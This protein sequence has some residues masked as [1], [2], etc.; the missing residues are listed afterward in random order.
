MNVKQEILIMTDID[1]KSNEISDKL[2]Q[3][4][5]DKLQEQMNGLCDVKDLTHDNCVHNAKRDFLEVYRMK[6]EL[7]LTSSGDWKM[8]E[9]EGETVDKTDFK[10]KYQFL[11]EFCN[12]NPTVG[13]YCGCRVQI[14]QTLD[15]GI[16]IETINE[17]W[18]LL[19]DSVKTELNVYP[20]LKLRHYG[21]RFLQTDNANEYTYWP[22]WIRV[23]DDDLKAYAYT[24]VD[25][26]QAVYKS[27]FVDKNWDKR[28]N[29]TQ[30]EAF[31]K[32]ALAE[33][34][35]GE[36]FVETFIENFRKCIEYEDFK[37]YSEYAWV[38]CK[39]QK[40]FINLMQEGFIEKILN[41]SVKFDSKISPKW[42]ALCKVFLREKSGKFVDFNP[43][44]LSSQQT[45]IKHGI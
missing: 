15:L 20:H 30:A 10:R 13:I 38:Y 6:E 40:D 36:H 32:R 22:F 24:V 21:D 23:E 12:D 41:P 45:N 26:V 5:I 43:S 17:E 11:I 14:N 4:Y 34:V 35:G 1:F 37:P 31:S 27:Y 42:K 8:I 7:V 33:V 16:Q 2:R 18:K 19:K 9:R 29:Q 25:R 44:A 39:T 28:K 3:R